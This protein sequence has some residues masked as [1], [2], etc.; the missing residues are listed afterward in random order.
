MA[1]AW[2]ARRLLPKG[3]DDQESCCCDG[4]ASSSCMWGGEM[5]GTLDQ[6][7]NEEEEGK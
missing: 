5:L 3:E 7:S 1:Q 6:L 2:Q 4:S